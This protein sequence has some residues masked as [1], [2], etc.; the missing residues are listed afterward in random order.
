MTHASDH[1]T[2]WR[3]ARWLLWL[4]GVVLLVWGLVDARFRDA[5]G[6]L[7]GVIGLPLALS[8]SLIHI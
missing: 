8:L 6:A 7:A 3:T 5:E 1:V 2:L 4:L